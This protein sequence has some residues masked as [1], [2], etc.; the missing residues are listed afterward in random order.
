MPPP[1]FARSRHQKH[2]LPNTA[3]GQQQ[4]AADPPFG[5]LGQDE[6]VGLA[7]LAILCLRHCSTSFEL[8]E[9]TGLLGRMWLD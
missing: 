5:A 2:W 9:Q 6:G 1:Q 4:D 7:D 8:L 3:S